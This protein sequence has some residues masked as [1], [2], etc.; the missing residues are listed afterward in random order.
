[1]FRARLKLNALL[2]WMPK[3]LEAKED[4]QDQAECALKAFRAET[5][6]G[7]RPRELLLWKSFYIIQNA[8][9]GYIKWCFI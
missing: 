8:N 7:H 6:G 1:M 3:G 4:E 2:L 5:P 9:A